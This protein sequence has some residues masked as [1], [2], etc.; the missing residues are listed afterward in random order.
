MDG[1]TVHE[2][3]RPTPCSGDLASTAQDRR[4]WGEEIKDKI[5]SWD[6]DVFALDKATC[7][8][9]L[10]TM[11]I[12]LLESFDLLEGWRV[13]RKTMEAFL[14][15]VEREYVP[16]SYHNNIHAADVTQTAAIIL[17]SLAL[18][19]DDIPKID[20]FC[21]IIGAAVHDLGHLGV[22]NDFLINSKH[23]RATTYNDKS[24]N[25][26]YHISRAF[27]VVRT[28][29]GCDIFEHLTF[30]EQKK[31]RKLIVDAVLA[32]DMVVH[33]D[34]VKNFN[35]KV[36]AESDINAWGDRT[37]LYQMLI[38]LA[39][40]GNPSRPFPLARAWAERVIQEFCEQGDKE[41]AFGLTVSPF[42]NREN[43]NMPKAQQG[44][45]N[46]FLKPTLT[47]F[48]QVVPEFAGTAL[49]YLDKTLAE[50]GDLEKSGFK[51]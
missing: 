1:G 22:N 7:G 44:F 10:I 19:L 15:I 38:H 32:T 51:V 28:T 50:W 3:Y 23:P 4:R 36:A 45:I 35:D 49:E 40:I 34:L 24:V 17:K 46:V 41:A 25:E 18:H 13:D 16:N 48:H 21:I 31:C 5:Y 20:A 26:N 14:H 39:D 11:T 33:F 6:F 30:D 42:C 12:A 2:K 37:L 47:A 9:P 27:E 29:P 43:I 8:N